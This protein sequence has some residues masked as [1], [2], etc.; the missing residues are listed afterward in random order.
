MVIGSETDT[1]ALSLSSALDQ[2]SRKRPGVH[3]TTP[4]SRSFAR[5]RQTGWPRREARMRYTRC[6]QIGG[7]PRVG[8]NFLDI[9]LDPLGGLSG[10]MFVAALL[11]AFPE[12]WPQVQS[13]IAS[14]DLG[15][16]A[17]CRLAPHHDHSFA[18]SRFFVGAAST[19]PAPSQRRRPRR[20][21]R[22]RSR[23]MHSR[24]GH[25]AWADIRAALDGS[26]LDAD[27]KKHAIAIFQL[28]AE[29]EA[30][31]HG[32]EV[33]SVTFHEVGAV[34]SIVDIV[35]GAQLIALIRADRW[36]SAP[37]PIGSGRIMS[38]HGVLPVPAPADGSPPARP[39]R[40][41]RWRCGR[42]GD[43]DWRGLRPPPHQSR[44]A[45]ERARRPAFAQRR[46]VRRADAA[47]RQQLC[48]GAG[49][50]GNGGGRRR[51]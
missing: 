49:V 33:G 43:A 36:T 29:A 32:V 8:E 12:Y 9:H 42:A 38:A 48:A 25:R 2:P 40:H 6:R 44:R 7:P 5:F 18:G 4:E 50:R 13:A 19:A 39:A 17:D 51:R 14:L 11:D 37:L 22:G 23:L 3:R 31:V 45:A 46:R 27:V 35:A 1:G 24:G 10:D 16:E 41:R 30:K 26:R 15:A 34:D 28:L 21:S 47:R 20:S